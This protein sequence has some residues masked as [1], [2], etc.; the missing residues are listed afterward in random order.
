MSFMS[1][2]VKNIV[3]RIGQDVIFIDRT[4][5]FNTATGENV[6]TDSETTTKG[7][8]RKYTPRELTGGLIQQI[9]REVKVAI[10][11]ISFTPKE[12]DQLRIETKTYT[13]IAVDSVN[14]KN[15]DCL[16]VIQVRGNAN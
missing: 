6:H 8:V 7:F 3:N 5:V 4:S 16:Y 9:D 11:A 14:A 10:D 15:D 12:S 1:E 13:I 2:R